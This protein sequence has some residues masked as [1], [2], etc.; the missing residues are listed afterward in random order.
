MGN[1]QTK[2]N[3]ELRMKRRGKLQTINEIISLF[4]ATQFCMQ[5]NSVILRFFLPVRTS[6]WW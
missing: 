1:R 4:E 5:V 3:K 2:G 6:F